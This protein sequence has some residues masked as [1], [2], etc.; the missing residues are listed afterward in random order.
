M[1]EESKKLQ[2]ETRASLVA[3]VGAPNAG[4]S[5][6]VNQLVGAKVSIVSAKAQTTRTRVMGV[7]MQGETQLVFVDTP[8]IFSP[9]R[10][11][12][13]AMVH[14]AW[15]GADGAD[16]ICL[17]YDASRDNPKGLEGLLE[18]L[19]TQKTTRILVLNKVDQIKRQKLLGLAQRL[20]E[21][22]DFNHTFMVSALMGDGVDDLAVELAK[23]APKGPWLFPEDQLSDMQDRL[24]AAEITREQAFRQLGQEVPYAL[25]VETEEWKEFQNGEVRVE[26]TIYVE[27]A[28]QRAIVLGKSGERIRRIREAAQAELQ[29]ATDR[30]AHLFLFVKVRANW[31]EDP[32][33]Y[34]P[35]ALDYNAE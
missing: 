28:S 20:N 4:K 35:W 17:V 19:Q 21:M 16:A 18:K 12:D 25:T 27:R 26:Q 6:L 33:R 23:T 10:R 13:R 7:R 5:T 1:I 9:R 32:E 29:E 22:A 31:T 30:K 3:L 34:A 15:S 24:F 14:A 11:L 2:N 8:G